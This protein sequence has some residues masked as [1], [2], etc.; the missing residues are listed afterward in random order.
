[1]TRAL[2]ANAP[3]AVPFK[4]VVDSREQLPYT[5]GGLRA[6][7][8]KQHRPLEIM[9]VCKTLPAGDYS[10]EGF[11]TRI[12]IERKS[13]QDLFS[14]LGQRRAQFE[15]EH[16]RLASFEFAAVVIEASWHRIL[17]HPPPDSLLLPK[18]VLRTSMSWAQRYGVHWLTYEN[19]RAAEIMTFRLLETFWKNVKKGRSR[20][21]YHA[22]TSTG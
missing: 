4:V 3:L 16:A 11:E 9:R 17:F 19:R 22:A 20:Y 14:T 1:M 7:A 12:A 21:G 18:A 15:A 8:D 5:F 13:L 2:A 6:D 10:I